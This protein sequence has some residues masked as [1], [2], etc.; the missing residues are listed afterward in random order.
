[1]HAGSDFLL[2]LAMVLGALGYLVAGLL[3]GP[4]VPFPLVADQDIVHTL[5]ETGVI[6]LMFSIGLEFSL[7]KLGRVARTAGLVAGLQVT[8]M[9]WLGYVT[10]R[11]FGWTAREAWFTGAILSI[12]STTIIAK[13]FEAER[14]S[15][16]LR[17]LV[18]AVLI[19]E[20]LL[21]VL[22]LAGLSTV[23]KGEAVS[24]PACW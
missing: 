2:N 14:V 7:R 3:I 8:F 4:H 20:D 23:T 1:V 9:V 16:R 13:A 15:A 19:V 12:S 22:L 21:A 10:A 17:E 5:S 6:L 11:L 24:S 18:F